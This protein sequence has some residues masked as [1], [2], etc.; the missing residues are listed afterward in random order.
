[1]PISLY[2]LKNDMRRRKI[3]FDNSELW[4]RMD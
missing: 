3:Q 4:S 1:M 2:K